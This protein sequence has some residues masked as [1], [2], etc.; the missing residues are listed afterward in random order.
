M[1]NKF[2]KE[3]GIDKKVN[4]PN[5]VNSP[6]NIGQIAEATTGSKAIDIGI[7]VAT[8]MANKLD[9]A[10]RQNELLAIQEQ[11]EQ[12]IKDYEI[13]WGNQDKY[14]YNNY[15]QYL[16]GLDKIKDKNKT[17]MSNTNFTNASDVDKWN[18]NVNQQIRNKKF[19]EEGLRNAYR[20]EKIVGEVAQHTKTY[21]YQYMNTDSENTNALL[22]I[23]DKAIKNLDL[24]ENVGVPKWKINQKKMDIAHQFD[25]KSMQKGLDEVINSPE[26]SAEEKFDEIDKLQ[27]IFVDKKSAE[28]EYDKKVKEGLIK[29]SEGGK[30]KYVNMKMM[31]IDKEYMKEAEDMAKRGIIPN[32]KDAKNEYITYTK[33]RIKDS[34]GGQ[35]GMLN[36]AKIKIAENYN[37]NIDKANDDIE[38]VYRNISSG[39]ITNAIS[40]IEGKPISPTD[41]LSDDLTLKYYGKNITKIKD[42][43]KYIPMYS[44]TEINDFRRQNKTDR[45]NGVPRATTIKSIME[46]INMDTD[47]GQMRAR[48]LEEKGVV[49][50]LEIE[51]IDKKDGLASDIINGGSIGRANSTA[52]KLNNFNFNPKF[53]SKTEKLTKA[54]FT[55]AQNVIMTETITGIAL[56]GNY[57]A[58]DV[59]GNLTPS[60]FQQ[61]YKKND[62]FRTKVDGVAKIIIKYNP[63][64]TSEVKFKYNDK[65][66]Q[67]QIFNKYKF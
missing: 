37:K 13:S 66:I 44:L 58:L 25:L 28:E 18:F 34:L 63:I 9:E 22:E 64:K 65:Q 35:Y 57:G 55:Y 46:S 6:L 36:K 33:G 11:A 62:E 60:S 26:M 27:D 41:M 52:N 56:S 7:K 12:N 61:A 51:N 4:A 16:A 39:N 1:A 38:D 19:E 8:K 40:T 45:I 23:K 17:L 20:R 29:D 24:L 30:E 49:T 2:L 59:N 50:S 10:E 48:Q 21:E 32:T 53:I 5:F 67:K 31:D 47:E 42:E 43:K 3:V 54:K 14:E 15:K